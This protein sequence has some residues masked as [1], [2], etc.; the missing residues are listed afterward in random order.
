MPHCIFCDIVAKIIPAEIVHED[1]HCIAFHDANQQ[2]PVHLLIIP[3]KHFSSLADAGPE[4]EPTLGHLFCIARKMSEQFRIS[5]GYRLVVNTGPG[6][7]QTVFHF[8]MHV[9]GGRMFEWPPG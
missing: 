8:H 2:A 3:R 4:D 7:G 6:A 1:E 5:V 9:I